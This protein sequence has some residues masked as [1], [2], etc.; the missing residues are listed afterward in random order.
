M[1]STKK[2]VE[3]TFPFAGSV[4]SDKRELT[5]DYDVSASSLVPSSHF[6]H[7]STV[8]VWEGD[9]CVRRASKE[10]EASDGQAEEAS[11]AD[12]FGDIM[13]SLERETGG[14]SDGFTSADILQRAD[15]LSEAVLEGV[16]DTP[17][18]PLC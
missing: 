5:K 1:S 6:V 12:S 7:D 10:V 13:G 15:S 2:E 17:D 11:E 9:E 4:A 8:V 18:F 3:N 16:V 14:E